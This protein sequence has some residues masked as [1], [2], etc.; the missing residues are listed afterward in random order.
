MCNN[1]YKIFM[2]GRFFCEEIVSHYKYYFLQL[3]LKYKIGSSVSGLSVKG[4]VGGWVG[5]VYL[6]NAVI[7]N[8]VYSVLKTF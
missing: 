1:Y 2:Q 6:S 8:T 4:G 5:G 7:E 3:I